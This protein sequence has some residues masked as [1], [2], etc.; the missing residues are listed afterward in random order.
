M[1]RIFI[2]I[3]FTVSAAFSYSQHCPWDCTGMILLLTRLPKEKLYKLNP[4]LVDQRLRPIT[5]TMFGTGK[6][7]ETS[8]PCAFLY[9]DDFL[10]YRT[11][12]I[13]IHH[14]Y[15]YDT[16]YYFAKGKYMV[17]FNFCRYKEEKLFLRFEDKYSRG[18]KYHYVEIPGKQRI[19]L[20]NYSR[21]LF[22]RET[23]ALKKKLKPFVLF[24]N[25]EKWLLRS[26]DC[27]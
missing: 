2:L 24:M 27:E 1:K 15:G 21:E 12:K 17:H 16:L 13:A 25:C 5:D 14:W 10:T 3:L 20:H 7:N 23:P 6:E 11:N 26:E 19:H 18:I 22:D 4:V 9:Y 8:D